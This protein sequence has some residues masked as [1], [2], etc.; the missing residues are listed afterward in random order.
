MDI[1]VNHENNMSARAPSSSKKQKT[2]GILTSGGDA[3]GMNSVIWAA[4]NE[5]SIHGHKVLGI[6]NGYRGLLA[7]ES[8]VLDLKNVDGIQDI[9]GTILGTAR[10]EEMYTC[11]GR[12]QAVQSAKEM[13]LDA[14]LIIGGEGSYAGA[15][16]ISKRNL[17]TYCVPGTIDNDLYYSD[18]SIGFDTALNVVCEAVTRIRDTMRSHGRIGIVEVMGRHCGKIALDT[19]LNCGADYVLI[20]EVETKEPFDLP[21]ILKKI[22]YLREQGKN[23]AII[24]LA[25]GVNYDI[26]ERSN[27]LRNLIAERIGSGVRASVLGYQQ[28]GGRPTAMDR[29]HAMNMGRLAMELIHAGEPSCAVGIRSGQLF[30]QDI[31][32]ALDTPR[33][34][35]RDLYNYIN[36]IE[37]SRSL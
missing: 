5:A 6:R 17:P 28:R 22:D 10:C 20:P 2:I 12:D 27:V 23:Y 25:E 16:E 7:Q 26:P 3:V 21:N 36:R 13:G 34:F 24:I 37:D 9:G 29:G 1:I 4:Y 19:A 31:Q 18:Y 30:H 33:V 15:L 14:L 11:A 8:F 32:I 35:S